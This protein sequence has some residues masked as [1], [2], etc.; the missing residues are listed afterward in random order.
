MEEFEDHE[1]G[2][3]FTIFQYNFVVFSNV[4]VG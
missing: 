4:F 3:I 2:T 1:V